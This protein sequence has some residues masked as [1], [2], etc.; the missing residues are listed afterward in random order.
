MSALLLSVAAYF[1]SSQYTA[2]RR[3]RGSPSVVPLLWAQITTYHGEKRQVFAMEEQSEP[4]ATSVYLRRDEPGCQPRGRAWAGW[5]GFE[6][7]ASQEDCYMDQHRTRQMPDDE[8]VEIA[9]QPQLWISKDGYVKT[10]RAG[11]V[12]AGHITG[13]GRSPIRWKAPAVSG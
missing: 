13:Q 6:R 3:L 8:L 5:S 1:F 9:D 11:L 4:G 10:L 2:S 12:R 7:L